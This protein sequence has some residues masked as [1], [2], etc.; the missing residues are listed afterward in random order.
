MCPW[1]IRT[2]P[3]TSRRTRPT[4]A[5]LTSARSSTRSWTS[6]RCARR[7]PSRPPISR[8]L[9]R[10]CRR[11]S[12]APE[13]LRASHILFKTEG[14]DDAAVKTQAED[15]LKQAKSG[16]DFGE[17][18]KKYSEDDS[19]AK[20]GGDL[21]YFGRGRMVPEFD[22]AAFNMEPGQISDLV[23]SQFGYPHHQ[24][25]RQEAGHHPSARRSE[26]AAHRPDP[27]RARAGSRRATS[28][29]SSRHKSRRQPIS[30]PRR[31]PGVHR[32]RRPVSSPRTSRSSGSARHPR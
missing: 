8:G 3:A 23:K 6:T 26:A 11:S 22:A 20:N 24:A 7:S 13:Q 4:S 15:I 25:D 28:R 1:P 10:Q 16:A 21:D 14:K 18:A 27:V 19:N 17:L 30:R 32:S 29:R 5:F 12:P 9:Q 31:R 2:S